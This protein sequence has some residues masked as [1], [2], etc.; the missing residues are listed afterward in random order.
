MQNHDVTIQKLKNLPPT[1][2]RWYISFFGSFGYTQAPEYEY[3]A[4][5]TLA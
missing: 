3:E 2:G 1:Q 4:E 5:M